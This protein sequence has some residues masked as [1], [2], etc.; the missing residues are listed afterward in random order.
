MAVSDVAGDQAASA[1]RAAAIAPYLPRLVIEWMHESPGA[2]HRELESTLVFVDISGFTKLSE[3]LARRGKLGAEELAVT[4]DSCFEQLLEIAYGYGANL[5][6]FG[7][8]A[9]LLLFSGDR[10]EVRS[11]QAAIAMRRK[12]REVGHLRVG[13]QTV[14]LRMSVGLHSGLFHLFLVGDAHRELL[15]TGPGVSA[16]VGMEAAADAGDILV[17]EQTACSP[18]RLV[19]RRGEG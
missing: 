13:D 18:A 3:R 4:I 7:G 5:L 6:K 1:A 8:D 19:P 11:S 14:S 17:S 15:L 2:I 9:L 10:H 12:L 16:T